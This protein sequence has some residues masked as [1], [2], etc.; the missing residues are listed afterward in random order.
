MAEFECCNIQD[1]FV[2]LH[3]ESATCIRKENYKKRN[4]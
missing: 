2:L 4:N 3:S 1:L